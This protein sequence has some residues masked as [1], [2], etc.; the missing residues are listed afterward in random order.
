MK[1]FLGKKHV[2]L[3]TLAVALGVAVYLNYYFAQ[4]PVKIPENIGVSAGDE[5]EQNDKTLGEALN[6]NGTDVTQNEEKLTAAEYFA[7]ARKNRE[8]SREEATQ[9]VKDLMND[10]K[11][12]EEQKTAVAAQVIAL[13]KAIE[14]ESK[15]E[16]LVKAK[17]FK[18][19]VAYIEDGSCSIV[20][21]SDNLTAQDATRISQVVT[22]QADIPA[23]KINI[24]TVN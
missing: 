7:Q 16:N 1:K 22:S 12:T 14:Q 23:Q 13:T 2:L 5:T 17:G 9:T 3:G 24:V 4:S 11:A 10:V 18:D 20:V 21:Q 19:C 15:I 8:V 6:V